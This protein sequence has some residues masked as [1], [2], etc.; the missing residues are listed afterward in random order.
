VERNRPS[1][2]LLMGE[3]TRQPGQLRSSLKSPRTESEPIQ[4]RV[5]QFL[6]WRGVHYLWAQSKND[7]P[8]A[9]SGM[10]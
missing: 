3:T 10:Q 5:Y 9:V 7:K 6:F 8:L 1:S 4:L 2:P